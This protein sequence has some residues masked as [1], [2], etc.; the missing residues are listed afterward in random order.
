M[1]HEQP[2]ESHMSSDDATARRHI[3]FGTLPD[4]VLP[5]DQVESVET[6]PPHGAPEPAGDEREWPLRWGAL[7]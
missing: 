7:G 3:T 4:R 2:H 6:D 5:A 1:S